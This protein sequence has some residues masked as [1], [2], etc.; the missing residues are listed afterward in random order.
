MSSI[1]DASNGRTYA[2][3]TVTLDQGLFEK[4]IET[5]GVPEWA[6]P[7][8]PAEGSTV[9]DT[10]D[11]E[12]VI[13]RA[14]FYAGVGVPLDPE[15]VEFCDFYRVHPAQVMP[16][17]WG[18]LLG[19]STLCRK[20]GIKYSLDLFRSM[21]SVCMRN[22]FIICI[23]RPY[24]PV[25]ERWDPYLPHWRSEFLYVYTSQGPWVWNARFSRD[26][27]QVDKGT[28]TIKPFLVDAPHFIPSLLVERREAVEPVPLGLGAPV[29]FADP[30]VSLLL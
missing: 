15:I 13:Y 17:T 3:D 26:N 29:T 30:C 22:R 16:R 9:L 1:S 10:D 12:V 18:V 14:S 8:L 4:T 20:L 6:Q 5:F 19:L 27:C 7:R 28:E 21:N 25:F 2:L 23:A 24:A 11:G